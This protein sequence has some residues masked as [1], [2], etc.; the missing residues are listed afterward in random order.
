MIRGEKKIK[1]RDYTFELSGV[2][3]VENGK[4][5]YS[6]EIYKG[7]TKIYKTD[8][9]YE[10]EKRAFKDA[11]E[12]IK[13]N[14]FDTEIIRK[15]ENAEKLRRDKHYKAKK[16]NKVS[17]NII[18]IS[19]ILMIITYIVTIFGI[20]EIAE[21]FYLFTILYVLLGIILALIMLFWGVFAKG[22]F[23]LDDKQRN[24]YKISWWI[25]ILCNYGPLLPYNEQPFEN[26]KKAWYSS[27]ALIALVF[28]ALFGVFIIGG[29]IS[30]NTFGSLFYGT[31]IS[32]ILLIINYIF[33]VIWEI[34]N[35]KIKGEN[36]IFRKTVVPI[37]TIIAIM[38]F[39]YFYMKKFGIYEEVD[40]EGILLPLRLFALIFS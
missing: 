12:M 32:Y 35:A 37:L 22:G 28:E 3:K 21:E 26:K 30:M 11:K 34:S 33:S 13:K 40:T 23:Q 1:Y 14:R 8:W 4:K 20:K 24:I 9:I 16:I 17:N 29:C 6:L 7:D 10:D 15:N 36:N 31:I 25:N 18:V 27:T 2:Y 38:I 19:I 39:A 5:L